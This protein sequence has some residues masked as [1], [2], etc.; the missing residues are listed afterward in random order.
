[1]RRKTQPGRLFAEK[2]TDAYLA[3]MLSVFLLWPGIDGYTKITAV[4]YRLFLILTA[5]ADSK[6]SCPRRRR[7][8]AIFS[9]A[10]AVPTAEK[11][12]HTAQACAYSFYIAS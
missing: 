7:R 5:Q 8:A 6:G 3:L 12:R 4:K 1:M 9:G 11:Q 10:Q 2:I